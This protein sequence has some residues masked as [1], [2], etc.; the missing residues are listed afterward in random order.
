MS[1]QD[2]DVELKDRFTAIALNLAE[3][4]SKIIEELNQSQ[5]TSMDVGGYYQPDDQLAEK[6]MRPSKTFNDCLERMSSL[7]GSAVL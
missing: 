4:E 1:Q 3:N 7:V 2:D 5:G 6:A